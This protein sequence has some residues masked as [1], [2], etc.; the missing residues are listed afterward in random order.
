MSS[1]LRPEFFVHRSDG[2]I[3]PLIAVDELPTNITIHG[4]P[5]V[6]SPDQTNG[7]LSLGF[8]KTRGHFYQVEGAV[9]ANA[10]LQQNTSQT[11]NP[12]TAGA[13]VLNNGGNA[14]AG[15]HQRPHNRNNNN[16]KEFCSYWVR[17]GECDYQQQGCLYKH[18]IPLD[19][20][21][22]EKLG[23][24]D[25]P[26]W[27][28]EKYGIPSLQ[29][30]HGHPRPHTAN[31]HEVA[32]RSNHFP[33]QLGINGAGERSN[34]DG[35]ANQISPAYLPQQQQHQQ[36]ALLPPPPFNPLASSTA[37]FTPG[38]APR[39]SSGQFHTGTMK[40]D[41]ISFDQTDFLSGN[42]SPYRPSSKE[43]GFVQASA[44]TQHEEV[45]LNYHGLTLNTTAANADYLPG[46]FDSPVNST[47]FK[48]STRSRRLYEAPECG[49][50]K[51]AEAT[52]LHAYH[53]QA[54]ASS[55]GTSPASKTTGSVL[56]SPV[57]DVRRGSTNSNP[58]TRGPSPN[59]PSPGTSPGFFRGR[60]RN[61]RGHGKVYGA[62]GAKKTNGKQSADSSEEDLYF[63]GKK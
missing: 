47:G 14:G 43:T 25:I 30:G 10:L 59:G 41:L 38:Q 58:S 26:R 8:L 35:N 62:V 28:R 40:Q 3:T 53:N 29:N 61:P 49:A 46:H 11:T 50:P 19:R 17:H 2:S 52:T 63:H 42:A 22:L 60:G 36:T 34:F 48:A 39:S 55:N 44:K 45:R 1:S 16:N 7:M 18:E 56:P 21:G 24:R 33:P 6:L 27:Y 12:S 23:L 4:A 13:L 57:T 54:T 9:S 15:N 20:A 31:N 32:V 37:P 5:R 51:L